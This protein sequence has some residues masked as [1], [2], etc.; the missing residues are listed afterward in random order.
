MKPSLDNLELFVEVARSRGF[1]RAG[2]V[3]GLPAS[4]LSRRIT[5]LEKSIGVRLLNRTTRKVALTEAGAVYFERCR[6]IVEEARVAHELLQEETR[7]PRGHLRVSLPSGL[8]LEFLQDALHDFSRQYP[9]IECEYDLSIR[10]IDLQMDGYDVVVRIAQLPDSSIVSRT[11][12]TLTLGLY[13]SRDYVQTHGVPATPMD[14]AMHD[15]LRTSTQREDSVWHL[16]NA[17][18][19]MQPVRVRGR[20]AVNQVLMLRQLIRAGAGI[21]QLP[22]HGMEGSALV[23]VL[24][25][26]VFEPK[27]LVALFPSRMMPARTRVF[28]DFLAQRLSKVQALHA[29]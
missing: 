3:L 1:T 28:L 6:L 27:H 26:W 18:G 19:H 29:R 17:S 25:E 22:I 14:L 16:H 10:K 12:G 20:I 9:D 15:C 5:Q 24:P 23:R 8:V 11:L 7:L 4:T 2:A 21:G 13:A